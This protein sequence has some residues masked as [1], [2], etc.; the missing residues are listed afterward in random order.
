LSTI[1]GKQEGQRVKARRKSKDTIEVTVSDENGTA[2]VILDSDSVEL[3][4]NRLDFLFEE[5]EL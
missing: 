2:K 1:K 4:I 3:L 5:M